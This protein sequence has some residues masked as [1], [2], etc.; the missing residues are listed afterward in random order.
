MGNFRFSDVNKESPNDAVASSSFDRPG[1]SNAKINYALLNENFMSRPFD[2]FGYS[3][4]FNKNEF[5]PGN[6]RYQP[7]SGQPQLQFYPS[8]QLTPDGQI[9]NQDSSQSSGRG[10]H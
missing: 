9:V 5:G 2:P 6:G 3:N 7:L 10:K 8:Q 4:S 1:S